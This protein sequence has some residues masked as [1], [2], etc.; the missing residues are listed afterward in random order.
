VFFRAGKLE[1]ALAR[2]PAPRRPR[3]DFSTFDDQEL[4][5]LAALAEKVGVIEGEPV[6]T[7]DDLAVLSRLDDKLI[8][9]MGV[10]P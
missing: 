7:E 5:D 9:A 6:W 2:R 3:Y 8:A 1:A 10:H 4:E